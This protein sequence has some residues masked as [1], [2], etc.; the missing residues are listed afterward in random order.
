MIIEAEAAGADPSFLRWA[1]S[2]EATLRDVPDEWRK[3]WHR[4]LPHI[5]TPWWDCEFLDTSYEERYYL[6]CR[7]NIGSRVRSSGTA[8]A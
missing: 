5:A 6:R 7:R 8:D 1:R 3:W 4:R 2:E